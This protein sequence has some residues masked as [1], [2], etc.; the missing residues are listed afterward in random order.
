ME[1]AVGACFHPKARAYRSG[2]VGSR[3]EVTVAPTLTHCPSPRQIIKV[4]EVRMSFPSRNESLPT[5]EKTSNQAV[6]D[7]SPRPDADRNS[8]EVAPFHISPPQALSECSN[9][10]LMQLRYTA[11]G[12]P[13]LPRN[14]LKLFLMDVVVDQHLTTAHRDVEKRLV[15]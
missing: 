2:V 14:I 9:S 1:S 13:H 4:D 10:L 12:C 7:H 8:E 15:Q 11:L 6:I 5:L 3:Q